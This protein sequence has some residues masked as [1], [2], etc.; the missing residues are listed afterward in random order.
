MLLEILQLIL[1][2]D[3]ILNSFEMFFRITHNV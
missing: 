2:L 3:E 1:I